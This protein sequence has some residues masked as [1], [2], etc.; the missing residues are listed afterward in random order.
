M[1]APAII[2]ADLANDSA[3]ANGLT[4]RGTVPVLNLCRALVDAGADP[5]APLHV[6]RG[7]M[8]ALTVKS[9]RAGARLTI[10]DGDDGPPRL[11]KWEPFQ[12][13]PHSRRV[14]PRIAPSGISEGR[15]A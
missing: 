4:V 11:V 14:S 3:T 15:V 12:M 5:E 6:Y 8:L 2:C 10:R 9:I 7:Q 13:P 1:S